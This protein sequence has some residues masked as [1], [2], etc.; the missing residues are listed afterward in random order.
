MQVICSECGQPFDDD[1]CCYECIAR[2]EAIAVTFRIALYV[3]PF[4]GFLGLVF[5]DDMYH[6]LLQDLSFL[7]VPVI[8]LVLALALAFL[9]QDKLTRY[10][11]FTIFLIVFGAATFLYPGAYEFLNGFLDRNPA[12]EI[13]TQVLEKGVNPFLRNGQF[14]VLNL[15]LNRKRANVEIMVN[16]RTF[17]AVTPDDSVHLLF[18]PGA[19]SL[20]WHDDGCP[21]SVSSR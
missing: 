8:S 13:T 18:H 17:N 15:P 11:I 3:A 19:F 14:I 21:C 10:W 9:L 2:D 5:V 4:G 16:T 1:Q 7:I 20:P 12:I 6:P